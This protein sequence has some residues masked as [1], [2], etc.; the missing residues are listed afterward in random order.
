[1]TRILLACALLLA[2]GCAHT[3]T[4]ESIIEARGFVVTNEDGRPRGLWEYRPDR[5]ATTFSL[6]DEQER[7]RANVMVFGDQPSVNLLDEN[8]TIR[9]NMTYQDGA[10]SLTLSGPDGAH[11]LVVGMSSDQDAA[12]RVSLKTANG[13]WLSLATLAD[14][15]G[16]VVIDADGKVLARIRPE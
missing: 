12:P 11:R 15:D 2:V 14:A 9:A 6:L 3:H 5:Q 1:M 7:L 8:G 10:P 4:E 13:T 16:L